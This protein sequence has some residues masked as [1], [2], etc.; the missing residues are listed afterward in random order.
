MLD[1]YAASVADERCA[2]RPANLQHGRM[3]I[4]RKAATMRAAVFAGVGTLEIRDVREPQAEGEHDVKVRVLAC[5][6]CG[7]YTS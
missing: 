5:G 2:R 3:W 6:I 7:T 1:R 4:R